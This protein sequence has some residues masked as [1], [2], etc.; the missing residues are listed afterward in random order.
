MR[1]CF[2][3]PSSIQF[4]DFIRLRPDA[5]SSFDESFRRRVTELCPTH[6]PAPR[7]VLGL[8]PY[9][10]PIRTPI[11]HLFEPLDTRTH[12]RPWWYF[13]P[14]TTFWASG[15]VHRDLIFQ[16]FF[17]EKA[18]KSKKNLDQQKSLSRSQ[19][20]DLIQHS[21]SLDLR[22]LLLHTVAPI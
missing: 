22:L 20:V 2:F 7:T 13:L 21:T 12:G 16:L 11:S 18:P 10:A 3:P 8:E 14:T 6:K 19:G 17:K 1:V 15:I 5:V 9:P 4:I